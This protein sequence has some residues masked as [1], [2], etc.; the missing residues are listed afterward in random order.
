MTVTQ[1]HGIYSEGVEGPTCKRTLVML[2]R[3]D[4]NHNCSFLEAELQ[5]ALSMSAEQNKDKNNVWTN[6]MILVL[7]PVTLQITN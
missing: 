5:R 7:D 1:K 2:R 6:T 3:W 4:L